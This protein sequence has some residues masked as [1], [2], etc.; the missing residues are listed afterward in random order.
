MYKKS[1]Y[2]LAILSF[3]FT[4]INL[5]NCNIEIQANIESKECYNNNICLICYS[6]KDKIKYMYVPDNHVMDEKITLY[7][8]YLEPYKVCLKQDGYLLLAFLHFLLGC[9]YVILILYFN[10]KKIQIVNQEYNIQTIDTDNILI[11]YNDKKYIVVVN[12]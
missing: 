3:S 1:L 8:S 11:G 10:M 12:P 9:L 6:Y 2:V 5:M 7:R 4:F